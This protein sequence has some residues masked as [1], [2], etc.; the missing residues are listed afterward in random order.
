MRILSP[1]RII[2]LA[3]ACAA[4][5][6]TVAPAHGAVIRAH[7]G[8]NFELTPSLTP[9]VFTDSASGVAQISLLGNCSFHADQVVTL[10]A[11][12]DQ[13]ILVKGNWRFASADGTTT[14]DAV[15][16]GTGTPDP[17]NP[18]FVNLHYKM[19]FTGRTGRMANVRGKA[20][21]EVLAMFTSASTGTATWTLKGLVLAR[22]LKESDG[23][24]SGK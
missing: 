15:A 20:E 14:L 10:P 8:N 19:K 2:T 12:A 24:G 17:V 22:G 6:M 16:E 7:G 4:L 13:P 18:A 3:L 21:V 11:A 9:G 1:F 5:A 23:K